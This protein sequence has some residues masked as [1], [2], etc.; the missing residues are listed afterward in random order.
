MLVVDD[1]PMVRATVRQMGEDVG[2]AVAAVA[3]GA[4]ARKACHASL[5]DVAVIDVI[6]PDEDGVH[7]MMSLKQQHPDMAL[8][9]M[10]GGGRTGN[11]DLLQLARHAG[12]D[13]LLRKPFDCD[14]FEAAVNAALDLRLNGKRPP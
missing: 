5:F 13:A 7:A 11:F 3:S 1:D 12:A 10:S 4:A 2:Y 6:M 9:A 14:A 8:V